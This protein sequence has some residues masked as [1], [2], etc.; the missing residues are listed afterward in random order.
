MCRSNERTRVE[1][2]HQDDYVGGEEKKEGKEF[3]LKKEKASESDR[4][5]PSRRTVFLPRDR[6]CLRHIWYSS[7]SSIL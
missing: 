4:R 2:T 3:G 7:L 5:R 1:G 6:T